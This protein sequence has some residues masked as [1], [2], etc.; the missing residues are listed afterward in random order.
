MAFPSPHP[1]EILVVDDDPVILGILDCSLQDEGFAVTT[2]SNGADGLRQFDLGSFDIV[3][4]DRVMP[5][6]RGDELAQVI[7][8][9]APRTRVILITGNSGSPVNPAYFD[10]FLA[11]PFTL[12]QLLATIRE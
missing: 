5:V 3:I 1:I 2:A 8:A 7:K 9:R 11:K 4:S 10:A 12:N 6:M